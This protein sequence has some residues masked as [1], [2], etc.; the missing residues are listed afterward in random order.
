MTNRRFSRIQLKIPARLS[1]GASEIY[2]LPGLENLS[3]GG[4]LVPIS[5]DVPIGT[6]CVLII[7]LSGGPQA[8]LITVSGKIVRR[9]ENAVAVQFIG[10]NPED[11]FH[12]QNLIRYNSP[13]PD[14]IDREIGEH[15][16][17]M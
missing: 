10:I 12:L 14:A 5:L 6:L 16:G 2:D 3:I 7:K 8:T 11:L 4:C 1:L 17:L 15:P 13:D 9:E